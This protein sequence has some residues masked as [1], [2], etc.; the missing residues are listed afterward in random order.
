LHLLLA[1]HAPCT[2]SFSCSTALLHS[3]LS[4]SRS[5]LQ[6]LLLLL[7]HPPPCTSSHSCCRCLQHLLVLLLAHHVLCISSQNCTIPILHAASRHRGSGSSCCC[8]L[9]VVPALHVSLEPR[10]QHCHLMLQLLVC[11]IKNRP[12][13]LQQLPQKTDNTAAAAAF[14]ISLRTTS[15]AVLLLLWLYNRL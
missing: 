3:S 1:H 9:A 14:R 6:L 7:A 5:L 12:V 11:S 10:K 2:S 4:C 13:V 15:L 8:R